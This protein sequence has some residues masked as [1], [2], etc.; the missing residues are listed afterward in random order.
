MQFI[1]LWE[2]CE[3][4]KWTSI[5]KK[6]V[7]IWNVPVIA[8]WKSPSCFH[9]ISNRSGEVITVSASWANAG[10]VNYFISPIFASDCSTIQSKDK[11]IISTEFVY[12]YLL[13][14]QEQIYAFQ[15]WAA[16]PHVYGSDL[17]K[18]QIPL[19]SLEIQKFI[20]A[21]L[22]K[23]S[24]LIN[25]KKEAIGK[26][27]VLTKS[28]FLEMFGDPVANEK[29][30]KTTPYWKIWRIQW[31]A[32]F[33][34]MDYSSYWMP[35]I[36]IG[37]VNK[38]FFD[39]KELVFLPFELKS[40]YKNYL[41]YPGD[42]VITL[43][44]TIWKDDYWNVFLVDNQYSEYLLNQRVAKLSVNNTIVNSFYLLSLLKVPQI[45]SL[46]IEVDRWVRQ[47]NISNTD[48][49]ELIIPIPPLELQNRFAKFV[50]KNQSI[51]ENQRQSLQ[52]LQELYDTT[53]QEIF[54]F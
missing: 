12:K 19:P 44:G 21:K 46:I 6:D 49:L 2:I 13:S 36:R 11:N 50:Q 15:Q 4:K 10:Y 17:E 42:I 53:M 3:I 40:S 27:E 54:N 22:D 28:V 51:I 9:S 52:K 38:G 26:T 23:I 30:W 16:Q 37:T 32:A 31:W 43:T 47:A 41:L 29:N 24:E 39:N 34:S 8:W 25:L 45:K 20:V 5:T 1:K 18:I 7:T 33:K 48:I 35:I 14:K